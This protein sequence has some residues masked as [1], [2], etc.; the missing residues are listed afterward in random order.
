[1]IAGA[2]ITRHEVSAQNYEEIVRYLKRQL[3]MA[4]FLFGFRMLGLLGLLTMFSVAS[5]FSVTSR[6]AQRQHWCGALAVSPSS[7]D[8]VERSG[9]R[10]FLQG[11]IST[12]LANVAALPQSS[13]AAENT[14]GD[15]IWLTGKSPMVPGQ[16]P[17]DKNDV[18]GTKRDPNFLRSI[19]DCKSKCE[20]TLGPDGLS[21]SKED[22]LSEC[23]DICCTT[24]EQCTFAIVQRI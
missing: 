1:M 22:C 23:Q 24:Y 6:Q 16:K 14:S 2:T 19:S 15:T 17:R 10:L 5:T 20:N 11:A 13:L 21:R 12:C 18:K 4:Q 8:V 3:R 7:D 9:R